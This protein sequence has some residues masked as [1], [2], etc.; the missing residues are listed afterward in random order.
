MRKVVFLVLAV[1]ISSPVACSEPPQECFLRGNQAYERGHY[2]DALVWYKKVSNKGYALWHN[3]AI[4]A[5]GTGALVDALRY[6]RHAQMHAHAAEFRTLEQ[7]GAQLCTTLGVTPAL[8]GWIGMVRLAVPPAWLFLLQALNFL[9][10]SL[11]CLAMWRFMARHHAARALCATVSVVL[12]QIG[13]SV[14]YWCGTQQIAIVCQRDTCLRMGND[15]RLP[16]VRP[17]KRG[18]ELRVKQR[19]K[20]WIFVAVDQVAGWVP[21]HSVDLIE[22]QSAV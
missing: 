5:Q 18:S 6:V 2:H 22:Q 20:G 21:V 3:M 9:L 12:L 13:L 10:I 11:Y 16:C 17:L 15:E 8:G 7:T 14:V 1:G 4:A 19:E